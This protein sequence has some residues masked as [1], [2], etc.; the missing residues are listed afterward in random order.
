MLVY[1]ILISRTIKKQYLNHQVSQYSTSKHR[2][3]YDD[4]L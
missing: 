2:N 1:F 4:E 3:D